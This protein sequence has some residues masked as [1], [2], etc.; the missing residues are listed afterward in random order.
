MQRH[1][2]ARIRHSSLVTRH[3]SLVIAAFAAF[4]A[5]AAPVYLKNGATGACDGSS[6]ANAYTNVDVAISAAEAGDGLLYVAR[7]VYVVTNLISVTSPLSIYGGFAGE[8]MDE[9]PATRDTAANQ[10]VFS[11][12]V[13]ANDYWAHYEPNASGFGVASTALSSNKIIGP[14]GVNLPPAFTGDYDGYYPSIQGSGTAVNTARALSFGSNATAVLDGLTFACFANNRNVSG[15]IVAISSPGSVVNDCTFIANYCSGTLYFSMNPKTFPNGVQPTATNC[16]FLYNWGYG[17][18]SMGAGFNGYY[19]PVTISNCTFLCVSKTMGARGNVLYAG[20]TGGLRVRNC[21]IVRCLMASGTSNDSRWGGTG[22]IFSGEGGSNTAFY[23]C[24]ISNCY[25]AT[26]VATPIPLIS[27][28]N[29]GSIIL[30]RCLL[31]GNKSVVQPIEGKCYA[32]IGNAQSTGTKYFSFEGCAFASNVVEATSVAAEGGSYVLALIGNYNPRTD[33]VLLN[34]TFDGNRCAAVEKEGVT[35]IFCRGVASASYSAAANGA[36]LANCAFY[37]PADGTYDIVQYG[38]THVEPIN[39]VNCVFTADGEEQPDPIYADVPSLI[40]LYSCSIQNRFQETGGFTYDGLQPDK[41][42]LARVPVGAGPRYALAAAAATPGIRDTCDV[43]TNNVTGTSLSSWNFLL[44]ESGASWQALSPATTALSGSGFDA[45]LVGDVFGAARP[46]GAFT[47]GPVQGLVEP[48]ETG[49]TLVLRR[50]PFG[51]GAFAGEAVQ[52]VVAG[53]APAPVTVSANDP[54]T[55]SFGGWYD[56]NGD[57]YSSSATLSIASL[58]AGTTVLTARLQAQVAVNL[59]FS[60][61]GH[62]TFD[63][64]GTDTATVEAEAFAAF[65][66][67]PA[68]TIDDGWFFAGFTL[69]ATVPEADTTY[70]ARIVTK[71]VRVIRVVPLEEAPETQDGLTWETAYADLAAAYAD[72]GTYRG[73]VWL[74]EGRYLLRG[75]VQMLPNVAVRGGFA[76]TEAS[77]SEADP[78]AHPTILTGDVN[79]NGVWYAYNDGNYGRGRIWTGTTFNSPDPAAAEWCWSPHGN[80]ADDTLNAFICADGVATNC[81]FDGL[82]FTCFQSESIR[83]SSGATDG[84]V[85]SR[86]R[87]LGTTTSCGNTSSISTVLVSGSPATFTNC[88]FN[89]CWH[90]IRL[91]GSP[92]APTVIADCVFTNVS[93]TYYAGGVFAYGG[94]ATDIRRCGF[95]RNGCNSYNG[96][97]S[98]LSLDPSTGISHNV[99]DCVFADNYSASSCHGAISVN[100]G[101]VTLARCRFAGNRLPHSNT[102]S[103]RSFAACAIATYGRLVLRDCHI[104]G[105]YASAAADNTLPVASVAA[106]S[107]SGSI[108]LANCTV[109]TNAV[110]VNSSAGGATFVVEN[111]SAGQGIVLANTL[112]DASAIAGEGASEFLC[113]SANPTVALVNSVVRNES[114]GYKPFNFTS[115]SFQPTMASSVISGYDPAD[116]PDTGANGYLYDVVSATAAVGPLREGVNG[117]LARGVA[118]PAYAKLGRAVWLVGGVPYIYDDVANSSKPWRSLLSRSSYAASVT[119]LTLETPP[120]PDAFDAARKPRYCAPGPLNA[121]PM[122]TVITVK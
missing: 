121:A 119:G 101:L 77:A 80:Y 47:R 122:Q 56:E 66:A 82:T 46:A 15:A 50:D 62:G 23:D 57:L 35:P 17:S 25:T 20:T 24:V 51:A 88:L 96:P 99:S 1:S 9:T 86:C 11:G 114:A 64:T 7:G 89:G 38:S 63:S 5:N 83:V 68:F 84:L 65:P 16:R 43:A 97:A 107:G 10:T 111:T 102:T 54:N 36:G 67:V 14:N 53:G 37:G 60:L 98:A 18:A 49:A 59:T 70:T 112:V 39:I 78:A 116:M 55:Y 74:K 8:S 95:Y 13:T 26:S 72:A 85:V 118:G 22:N 6:W 79:D 31:A 33:A 115:A 28:G 76:G 104:S 34:C 44:P 120:L 108:V 113:T 19:G 45:K 41:V 2:T 103:A 91:T 58:A 109:E 42:P 29:A 93:A 21:E 100:G 48:A 105:N 4:A 106:T 52:A 81:V 3:S 71:D 73:E 94:H 117:A 30:E 27:T 12:D 61:D 40:R 87:F 90:G 110:T 75:P 32:M 69:P 92:A